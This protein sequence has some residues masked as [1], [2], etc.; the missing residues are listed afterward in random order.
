MDAGRIV[1]AFHNTWVCFFVFMRESNYCFRRVLA[2]AILSVR[3][4]VT[5]VNQSKTVQARIIKSS[6]PAA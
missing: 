4:S 1:T 2:I 6:P 5:R 3:P